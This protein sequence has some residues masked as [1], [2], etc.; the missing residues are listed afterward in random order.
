MEVYLDNSATTKPS[1]SVKDEINSVLNEYYGNP[2]SLHDIGLK[3][4]KR[5][6]KTRKV[7]S[8]YLNCL[9]GEITFTSGGTEANNLGIIGYAFRNRKKGKHI[10]TTEFE[11]KSVINSFKYLQN[12]GFDVTFL[13]VNKKGQID[14]EKLKS[15]IRKDTLLVSIMH[16]NNEVGSVLPI[17][18]IGKV[19]K[20][21]NPDTA[22]HVDGVQ[23]FGKYKINLDKVDM[24][25]FSGHKIHGI[26]GVGGLYK[27]NNINIDSI[28]KGGQQENSIRPGTENL[29]GISALSIAVEDS[30]KNIDSNYEKVKLLKKEVIEFIESN[31]ENCFINSPICDDYSPY[32]LSISV[33]DMMAEVLLHDL[34]SNKIYISTGSA[35]NSKDRN[36][37]HVL[38]AIGLNDDLMSG[39]I[40]ISFSRNTS[41]EEIDYFC[42]NFKSSVENL[43]KII[44]RR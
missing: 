32:I 42:K 17:N 36:F 5:I 27:K 38:E 39:T 25:S 34:E 3:S 12:Q 21:E 31:V 2:S 7:I 30:I 35:C 41:H 40:R 10:I 28:L 1:N 33:G 43:R 11:H 18:E 44:K 13:K 22:Y 26:K 9:P 19:I 15:E 14:I 20:K 23:A 29:I 4:E 6:N 24:Y 8:D 16:V 37:S